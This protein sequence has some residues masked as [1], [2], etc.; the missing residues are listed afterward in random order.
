MN[1]LQIIPTGPRGKE[2]RLLTLWVSRSDE[3]K[4]GQTCDYDS[5]NT[6]EAILLQ[7]STGDPRCT[8]GLWCKGMIRSTLGD[9][10]VTRPQ[11]YICSPSRGIILDPDS[12]VGFPVSVYSLQA[13][14]S[15]SGDQHEIVVRRPSQRQQ[16]RV[17]GSESCPEGNCY[18]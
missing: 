11:S 5:L 3:V 4:V 18:R 9:V 8:G 16:R 15:G 17:S 12:R 13:N 1:W 14:S 7:I 6:N 10:K 2:M